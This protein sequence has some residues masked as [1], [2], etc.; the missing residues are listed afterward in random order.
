MYVCMYV[1]K[2]IYIQHLTKP[3]TKQALRA[4]VRTATGSAQLTF[5]EAV[6]ASTRG[7]AAAG[8][9]QTLRPSTD[10]LQT[11]RPSTDTQTQAHIL[12]STLN[13]VFLQ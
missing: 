6:R 4:T 7:E 5:E 10:T 13:S 12:K 3:Y 11:L 9:L 1:C 8:T 2:Y